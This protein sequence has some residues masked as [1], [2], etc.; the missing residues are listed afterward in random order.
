MPLRL[1]ASRLENTVYHKLDIHSIHPPVIINIASRRSI[2]T[3]HTINNK[4]NINSISHTIKINITSHTLLHREPQRVGPPYTVERH[5]PR[6]VGLGV[7]TLDDDLANT[8]NGK[9]K[10]AAPKAGGGVIS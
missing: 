5:R 2:K 3:Q 10:L 9:T 1:C 8:H 4:L 6:E 7:S